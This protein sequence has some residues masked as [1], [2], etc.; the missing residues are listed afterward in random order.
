MAALLVILAVLAVIAV[1]VWLYFPNSHKYILG[2]AGAVAMF[3]AALFSGLA[4][5]IG[6]A[7]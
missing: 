1:A 2:A 7:G 5:L 3:L 6:R 4:D